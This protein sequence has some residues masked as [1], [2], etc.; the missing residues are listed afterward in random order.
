MKASCLLLIC[1]FILFYL[2]G[3]GTEITNPVY[4]LLE[5][6]KERCFLEDVPKDTLILA[7][8]KVEQ[9]L[10]GGMVPTGTPLTI[11]TK[12]TDAEG[13]LLLQREM[14]SE[15]RVA[16]TS[17]TSGEHKICF[18]TASTR[19]FGKQSLVNTLFFY[20]EEI[21]SHFFLF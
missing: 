13:K 5:E 16:F 21:F 7:T 6:G 11:K 17:Q 12:V 3:F 14:S 18:S 8:Y 19:W 4:F 15:N 9:G 20:F 2:E 1:F 10:N